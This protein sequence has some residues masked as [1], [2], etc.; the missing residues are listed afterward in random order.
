MTACNS[1]RLLVVFGSAPDSS[2]STDPHLSKH[3]QPP[4]PGFPR[5]EP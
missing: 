3:A 4:A 1:I 5:H 2:F